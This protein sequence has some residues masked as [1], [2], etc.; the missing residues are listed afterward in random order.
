MPIKKHGSPHTMVAAAR[1]PNR[2]VARIPPRPRNPLRLPLCNWRT[3]KKHAYQSVTTS[4]WTM[5]YHT[6]FISEATA[7][8]RDTSHEFDSVNDAREKDEARPAA[9]P[10]WSAPS[11]AT[12]SGRRD[13]EMTLRGTNLY[14]SSRRLPGQISIIILAIPSSKR[15]AAIFT[16]RISRTQPQRHCIA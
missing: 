2:I 6:S 9:H 4:C 12:R 7:A 1:S 16:S 10:H 11:A 13:L 8:F 15:I 5:T 14:S 3:T